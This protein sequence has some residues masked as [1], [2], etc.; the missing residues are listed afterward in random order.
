MRE[1]PE[2][3]FGFLCLKSANTN[4]AV[5]IRA[6]MISAFD[7]TESNDSPILV[8]I[9]GDDNPLCVSDTFDEI[10]EQLENIHPNLR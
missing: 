4:K 1:L 8:Y 5:Y 2:N 7:Y 3:K 10:L 9:V 6:N